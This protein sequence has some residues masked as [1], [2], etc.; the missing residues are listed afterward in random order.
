MASTHGRGSL[1]WATNDYGRTAPFTDF[2]NHCKPAFLLGGA[3]T[4]SNE[5]KQSQPNSEDPENT[6][7]T[8]S[9]GTGIFALN[10]F[11]PEHAN[12]CR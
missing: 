7:I 12:K 1:W 9:D 6:Q 11:A 3:Y 8:I 5:T 4:R 10:A 2:E